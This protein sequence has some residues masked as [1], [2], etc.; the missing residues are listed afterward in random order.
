MVETGPIRELRLKGLVRTVNGLNVLKLR[1]EK[2][3]IGDN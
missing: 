1:E 2:Q 3:A